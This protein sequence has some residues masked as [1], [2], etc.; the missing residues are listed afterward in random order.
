MLFGSYPLPTGWNISNFSDAIVSITNS[1][2]SIGSFSGTWT[3]EEMNNSSS[4]K[5]T[6]WTGYTEYTRTA[7]NYDA[8][9]VDRPNWR[10]RHSIYPDGI[11]KH[12]FDGTWR[13]EY[14]KFCE[15]TL[16]QEIK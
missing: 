15:G 16:Q 6:G 7:K 5:H 10:H 13:P 12:T 9:R 3:I 8:H 1:T 11:H 14:I 2:S 4:H